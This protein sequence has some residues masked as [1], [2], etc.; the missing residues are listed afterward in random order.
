LLAKRLYHFVSRNQENLFAR[1]PD[2]KDPETKACLP[3]GIKILRLVRKPFKKGLSEKLQQ[4]L[5]LKILSPT[6]IGVIKRRNGCGTTR[7][8]KGLVENVV[9]V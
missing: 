6:L 5:S 8:K 1:S 4:R 7:I 9:A 2:P 3:K